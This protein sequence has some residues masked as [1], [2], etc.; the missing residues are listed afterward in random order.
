MVVTTRNMDLLHDVTSGVK[1]VSVK[2]DTKPPPKAA[3]EKKGGAPT[4]GP[5]E[6][7][8]ILRE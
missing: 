5:L 8:W 3:K 1:N 2:D 4:A 7:R 6:V